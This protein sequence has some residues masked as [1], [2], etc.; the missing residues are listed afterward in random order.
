MRMYFYRIVPPPFNEAAFIHQCV[1]EH[2]VEQ[3]YGIVILL[4]DVVQII[5]GLFSHRDIFAG[6]WHK[7][8]NLL[9]SKEHTHHRREYGL[10]GITNI[11]TD[12]LTPAVYLVAEWIAFII[13]G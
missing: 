6:T 1:L 7:L 5:R 2:A 9:R 4:Y 10:H 13:L 8:H 12:N 3:G 11:T